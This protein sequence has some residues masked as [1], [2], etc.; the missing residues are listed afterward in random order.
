VKAEQWRN[1]ISILFIALFV[2]WEVNGEIP[3]E[4]ALPSPPNTRLSVSQAAAEKLL[5]RRR[6]EN[7]RMKNHNAAPSAEVLRTM[8]SLKMDR[9][10]RR[11]YAAILEFSAAVRILA[12]RAISPN[13]VRR[14]FAALSEALQSW[15]RM[16][17]HLTPYFHLILHM[18]SQYY[19]LGPCYGWWAF[20]YE[21]NNG[22]LGRFNNN[23]HS[24]GE[25]ECT[26]MR[27]WWKSLLI[28]DLV[29]PL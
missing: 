29:R 19:R 9:S 12:S 26:I 4:A 28:H 5:F 10:L 1:H 13:E 20:A 23:G 3:D 15:A 8:Q 14:G 16:N 18:E 7:F 11:H 24:G 25:L 22:T 17:C 2:A 27:C 6:V 21:R